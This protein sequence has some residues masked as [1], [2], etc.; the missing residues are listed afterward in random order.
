MENGLTMER[1][2]CT[3]SINRDVNCER[4]LRAE[5]NYDVLGLYQIHSI[6]DSCVVPNLNFNESG[7]D[8]IHITLTHNTFI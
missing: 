2:V 1:S 8:K 5:F 4:P 3:E 6:Q 7:I